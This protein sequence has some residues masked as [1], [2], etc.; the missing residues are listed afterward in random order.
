MVESQQVE[1]L[2][3]RAAARCGTHAGRL[4]GAVTRRACRCSIAEFHHR[5]HRLALVPSYCLILD[6]LRRA[7]VDLQMLTKSHLQSGLAGDCAPASSSHDNVDVV[8]R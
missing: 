7:L 6:G 5:A 3:T 2:G 4:E 8:C 1:W